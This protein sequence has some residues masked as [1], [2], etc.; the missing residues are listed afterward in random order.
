MIIGMGPSALFTY[1]SAAG[2]L[3][4]AVLYQTFTAEQQD[5]R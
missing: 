4:H 5:W 3:R 1:A 2:S